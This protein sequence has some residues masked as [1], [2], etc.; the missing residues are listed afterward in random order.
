MGNS[1][2]TWQNQGGG[3]FLGRTT[4]RHLSS[5]KLQFWS[6]FPTLSQ[7][8]TL[9]SFIKVAGGFTNICEVL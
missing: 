2:R 4:E 9:V 3:D 7:V 5:T 1:G 6:L 8:I